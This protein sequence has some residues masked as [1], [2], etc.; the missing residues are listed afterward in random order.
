[1]KTACLMDTE[2]RR[3]RYAATRDVTPMT[4]ETIPASIADTSG[5]SMEMADWF[6]D[7]FQDAH[8]AVAKYIKRTQVSRIICQPESFFIYF[9]NIVMISVPS[10]KVKTIRSSLY[11]VT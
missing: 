3:A 2:S 5:V 1:M 11:T 4:I 9:H 10:V 7:A 6:W 8:V